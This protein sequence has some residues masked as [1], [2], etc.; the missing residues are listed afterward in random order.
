MRSIV[1][2]RPFLASWRRSPMASD[3]RWRTRVLSMAGIGY[4]LPVVGGKARVTGALSEP[5]S[6]REVVRRE[7]AAPTPVERRSPSPLAA[8]SR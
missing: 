3:I 4:A 7:W 1:G 2:R 5:R 8:E 6:A